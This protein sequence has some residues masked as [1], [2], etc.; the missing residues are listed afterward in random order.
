[1]ITL[2]ATGRQD[3]DGADIAFNTLHEQMH[4]RG[5]RPTSARIYV[6]HVLCEHQQEPIAAERVFMQLSDA[7]VRLSLGTVYRV[8]GEL[9]QIGLVHKEWQGQDVGKHRYFLAPPL[10]TPEHYTFVCRACGRHMVV[11]DKSF[12]ALLQ[13]QARAAG[14]DLGLAT[15]ALDVTCNA[16]TQDASA[17]AAAAPA[18]RARRSGTMGR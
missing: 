5:L 1:M 7:G 18:A 17:S 12:A 8:L 2:P 16:C 4:R 6:L 14:F 9:Q 11:V 15:L 10:G 13:R 3:S